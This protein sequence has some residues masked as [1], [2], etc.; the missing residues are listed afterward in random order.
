MTETASAPPSPD[1]ILRITGLHKRYGKFTAVDHIDLEAP[2]GQVFGILGPNGAG[3]TTTLRM[4]TGLIKP[5]GGDVIIDGHAM[6]TDPLGAKA[7]T[8]FIPDRPYV[9]DKLT[10]F[11]YLRFVAGLYRMDKAK[12]AERMLM[13]LGLF[14][15]TEWGDSLIEG[16][17]HGMKQRL[18]FAGALLPTPRLLVV[19]EPM[20]GLDPK[21]H[22]LIKD[23]FVKL[24][25]DEGMTILLSTHTLEVAEEVC[26]QLAIVNH[27][28]VIA[29]GTL[30]ELRVT[31]GEG[32]GSLEEVFLAL[33][34]QEEEERAE[35]V[36]HRFGQSD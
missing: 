24:T 36:A 28:R 27:G 30:S 9:Y 23:L 21:G 35:A 14:E 20:V 19:D 4:I 3:K 22:R 12:A 17:S 10:A 2:R 26:D 13:L 11:E 5:T 7:I 33:T 16:F 32:E 6:S 18:V 15:L 29:R 34:K 1:A 31:S 8:G 25:R